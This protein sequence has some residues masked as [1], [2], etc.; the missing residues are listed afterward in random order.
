MHRD[1]A[2]H[3]VPCKQARSTKGVGG[4]C[5]TA[6]NI[7]TE[8]IAHYITNNYEKVQMDPGMQTGGSHADQNR[9]ALN[10]LFKATQKTKTSFEKG[11]AST[12]VAT[13]GILNQWFTA[14]GHREHTEHSTGPERY[15]YPRTGQYGIHTNKAAIDKA[16]YPDKP[17]TTSCWKP[18][19][20][21]TS[22]QVRH[23]RDLPPSIIQFIRH[24]LETADPELSPDWNDASFPGGKQVPCTIP[25]DNFGQYQKVICESGTNLCGQHEPKCVQKWWKYFID[26]TLQ[27]QTTIEIN[28]SF[29]LLDAMSCQINPL[30]KGKDLHKH[31]TEEMHNKWV[32]HYYEVLAQIMSTFENA[33]YVSTHEHSRWYKGEYTAVADEMAT[34]IRG[35]MNR[36]GVKTEPLEYLTDAMLMH[37]QQDLWHFGGDG[38]FN[39]GTTYAPNEKGHYWPAENWGNYAIQMKQYSTYINL[40]SQHFEAIG[41]WLPFTQTSWEQYKVPIHE[42]LFNANF[43]ISVVGAMPNVGQGRLAEPAPTPS[44]PLPQ[45]PY[46]KPHTPYATPDAASSGA[47]GGSF[48]SSVVGAMPNVVSGRESSAHESLGASGG[49]AGDI[50]A[51]SPR[52]PPYAPPD[53]PTDA[54]A[55]IPPPT[56]TP[57]AVHSTPLSGPQS[58]QPTTQQNVHTDRRTRSDPNERFLEKELVHTARAGKGY[59]YG[60]DPEGQ[61]GGLFCTACGLIKPDTGHDEWYG[62]KQ[63]EAYAHKNGFR[64]CSECQREGIVR[65]TWL[66][67]LHDQ[68]NNKWFDNSRYKLNIGSQTP[69][70]PQQQTTTAPTRARITHTAPFVG[71][72]TNVAQDPTMPTAKMVIPARRDPP[73]INTWDRGTIIEQNFLAHGF[74]LPTMFENHPSS[75]FLTEQTQNCI[76]EWQIINIHP[77]VHAFL[78]IDRI[79]H[80]LMKFFV[81]LSSDCGANV[82]LL[83]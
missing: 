82:F 21:H 10:F 43:P 64:K 76:S 61:V 70:P 3:G 40:R 75:S 5:N 23:N 66:A 77:S 47:L 20:N 72:T 51:H 36:W 37:Q 50:P 19:P 49:A 46:V 39:N 45:L 44:E 65:G 26:E 22:Q 69:P 58:Y 48:P 52:T 16:V 35:I 55:P 67:R 32:T 25:R 73:N 12:K 79:S 9:R 30:P 56:T 27:G 11:L 6:A 59:P 34:R 33:V 15:Q 38:A 42:C 78:N 1:S 53:F 81:G 54:T 2:F 80:E 71:Y 60:R 28:E 57:P 17:V 4:Y 74:H 13:Q 31:V 62:W 7:R 41:Y 8:R 29:I 63:D 83:R 24:G 14:K 68:N 18:I